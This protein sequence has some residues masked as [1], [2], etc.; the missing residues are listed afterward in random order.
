MISPGN[1]KLGIS[2]QQDGCDVVKRVGG[3][4]LPIKLSSI[5]GVVRLYYLFIG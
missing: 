1:P 4:Y 2:E 3:S 5:G